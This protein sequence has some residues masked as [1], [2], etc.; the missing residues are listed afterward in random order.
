MQVEKRHYV[1][2]S[3][4]EA[5]GTQAFRY[6]YAIYRFT[7]G[8]SCLVARGY[9]DQPDAAHFLRLDTGMQSRALFARDLETPL[10]AAA[11]GHLLGE[12]RRT[13][14]WLNPDSDTGYDLV[15]AAL[16]AAASARE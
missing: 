7:D 13:L 5:D 9:D 1:D 11:I 3:E 14:S 15:P 4:P 12:G 16:I 6:A 8:D 10:V 2:E